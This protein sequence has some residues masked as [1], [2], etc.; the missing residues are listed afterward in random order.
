MRVYL[1]KTVDSYICFNVGTNKRNRLLKSKNTLINA[2][3]IKSLNK[4]IKDYSSSRKV[5]KVKQATRGNKTNLWK[6][7]E[8]TK[9]LCPTNI[10]TNLTVCGIHVP[11]G[12]YNAVIWLTPS[13]SS[14]MKQIL[15]SISAT[16]LRSCLGHG[17]FEILFENLHKNHI[18]CTRIKLCTTKYL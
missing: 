16:A 7:V 11:V 1:Y 17:G 4:E 10:P 9:D 18:T 8:I 6:A 5:S 15:L 12:S 3:L 13:L 14:D 2:P